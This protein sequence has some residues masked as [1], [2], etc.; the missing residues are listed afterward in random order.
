MEMGSSGVCPRTGHFT[1]TGHVSFLWT[2][3]L[4]PVVLGLVVLLGRSALAAV[5]TPPV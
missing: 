2:Q 5:L 3:K 4:G 1:L